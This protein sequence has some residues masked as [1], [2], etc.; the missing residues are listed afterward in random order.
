MVSDFLSSFTIALSS[1]R[2]Y[3]VQG[4]VMLIGSAAFFALVI[5]FKSKENDYAR[6]TEHVVGTVVGGGH[7]NYGNNFVPRCSYVVDGVAYEVDGPLFESG[8]FAPGL[9][10][11]CTSREDLPATFRGPSISDVGLDYLSNDDWYRYSALYPLY[12]VGSPA[13]VYYEPGNPKHAYV[14]RPI[15]KGRL[16][17]IMCSIWGVSLLFAGLLSLFVL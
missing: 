5:Y 2:P 15:R 7:V 16:G 17:V 8:T 11:N 6:C 3:A 10:C 13:D 1:T 9:Q 14:Q 12:P 4:V